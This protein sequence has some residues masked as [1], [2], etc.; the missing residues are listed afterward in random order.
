V[1]PIWSPDSLGEEA[2]KPSPGLLGLS[3]A[4]HND[5]GVY[6]PVAH[7]CSSVTQLL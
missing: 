7:Y 2:I 3:R 5:A 6:N 1:K 4:D